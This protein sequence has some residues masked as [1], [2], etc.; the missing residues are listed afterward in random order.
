[1]DTI[2]P[3]LTHNPFAETVSITLEGE[4]A[5]SVRCIWNEP[6]QLT[7]VQG[8]GFQNSFPNGLFASNDVD[9][10]NDK[11]TMVR[12]G[13]TYYVMEVQ[14]DGTGMTTIIFSKDSPQ[15]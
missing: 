12:N 7:I 4:Q 11:A 3:F 8:V 6:Y 15:Q 2:T 1:M 10:I 13:V 9:G 14:P 5:K